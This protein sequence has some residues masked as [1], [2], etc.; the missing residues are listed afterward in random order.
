VLLARKRRFPLTSLALIT[1]NTVGSNPARAALT[2]SNARLSP[3]R[4]VSSAE[5]TVFAQRSVKCLN[6]QEIEGMRKVCRLS[7]EVLDLAAAALRPGITTEELDA[8]V[9]QACLDRDAYP[10]PLN[11]VRRSFLLYILSQARP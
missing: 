7:R 9:H 5:K 1:R 2:V 8:I 3:A 10:S 4:G 6:D 11:Y